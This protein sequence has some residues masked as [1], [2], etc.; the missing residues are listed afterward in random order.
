VTKYEINFQDCDHRLRIVFHQRGALLSLPASS[1]PI[2]NS[3][4]SLTA[5]ANM[6]AGRVRRELANRAPYF[7]QALYQAS[8]SE[9]KP[10]GLQVRI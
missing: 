4:N 9:E 2:S 10:P 7:E 6:L 1:T 8:A 5:A 3:D